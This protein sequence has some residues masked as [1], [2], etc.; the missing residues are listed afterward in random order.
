MA[1]TSLKIFIHEVTVKFRACKSEKLIRKEI[2]K[3]YVLFRNRTKKCLR[4]TRAARGR[5]AR[6]TQQNL[7]KKH[8]I[9]R[10]S[11]RA[12]HTHACALRAWNAI[13]VA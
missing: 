13:F 1:Q 12:S 8:T 2:L 3:S 9:A 6:E 11:A 10:V 4:V 5:C 7:F